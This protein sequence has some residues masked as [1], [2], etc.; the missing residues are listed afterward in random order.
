M[1]YKDLKRFSKN[2]ISKHKFIWCAGLPKSGTTLIEGVFDCLPYVRLDSS[3]LEYMT[4]ETDHGH[5]IS[6]EMFSN[7]QITNSHF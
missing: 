2:K 3:I 6:D 7:I 5:G 4:L 1:V